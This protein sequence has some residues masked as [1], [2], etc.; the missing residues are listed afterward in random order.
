MRAVLVALSLGYKDTLDKLL[1]LQQ[2]VGFNYPRLMQSPDIPT[3]FVVPVCVA[4]CPIVQ[5]CP[6][7]INSE[8]SGVINALCRATSVAR[9]T[10]FCGG[11]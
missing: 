5:R 7:R 8:C 3:A 10:Q 4:S 9:V 6:N 2:L 1:V 11:K